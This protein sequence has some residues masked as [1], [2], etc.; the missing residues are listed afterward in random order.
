MSTHAAE[1]PKTTKEALAELMMADGLD[2]WSAFEWADRYIA[3]FL[4]SGEREKTLWNRRGTQGVTMR[5][6]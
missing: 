2:F 6:R 1:K 5:R 4:A 3:E